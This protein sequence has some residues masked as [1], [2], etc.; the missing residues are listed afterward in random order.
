[1]TETHIVHV[2]PGDELV[3]GDLGGLS[4]PGR[5]VRVDV[6]ESVVQVQ[7]HLTSGTDLVVTEYSLPGRE[8]GLDVLSRVR[9]V[10][11]DL[12]VVLCTNDPDGEVASAATRLGV[13]EYVPRTSDSEDSLRDRVVALLRRETRADGGAAAVQRYAAPISDVINDAVVTIDETSRIVYANEAAADLTGYDREDLL[14]SPF[15]RLVPEEMRDRHVQAVAEYVRT[16][17]R[18]LDW[19]YLELT[20]EDRA[21]AEIPITVSFSEEEMD[22]ERFFTGVIRDVSERVER[23]RELERTNTRLDLALNAID[24]GVFVW[25]AVAD[26]LTWDAQTASLFGLSAEARTVDPSRLHELTIPEHRERLD[27][28]VAA[29][30]EGGDEHDVT[31]CIEHPDGE[32]RWVETHAT[33]V[34]ND[35]G[36]LDRLVGVTRDVTDRRRA[37]LELRESQDALQRLYAITADPD[38][39]FAAKLDAVLELGC[40]RLDLPLGFLTRIQ[41]GDLEIV[42]DHGDDDLAGVTA[43]L[44]ATYCAE[45]VQHDLAATTDAATDPWAQ[46]AYDEFGLACYIGGEIV[47][48]GDTHGTLCFAAEE[49]R[50]SDFTESEETFVELLTQWVGYERERRAREADIRAA[51]DQKHRVL[52]RIDAG[53]FAVDTDWEFTY[54][55][56]RAEEILGFEADDVLGENVWDT[57]PAAMERAFHDEYREAMRTQTPTTFEEYFPPLDTWFAVSAYPSVD[58]LSVYFEDVTERKRRE[59]EL[60]RYETIVE[61]IEDGVYALDSDGR[62]TFANEAL[63]DLTG[64]DREELL[65]R[66]VGLL[67][68]EETVRLGEDVLGHLLS[69]GERETTIEFDLQRAD[70]TSLP[71]EDR[72]TVLP[73]DAGE[74][75]GTA[76]V[77]RD[78]S[79]HRERE[80]T[81]TGLLETTEALMAAP[82]KEAVANVVV[83]AARETLGF[84]LNA[85][86]LYDPESGYLEPTVVTEETKDLLGDRPLYEPGEGFP[87]QVYESGEPVAYDDSQLPD[88][89]FGSVEVAYCLPLGEHGTLTMSSHDIDS[90]DEIDRQVAAILAANA[91]AALDRAERQQDLERYETVM[92]TVQHMVYVLDADGKFTHITRPFS[93]RLGYDREDLV[94]TDAATVIEDPEDLTAIHDGIR[95]LRAPDGPRST[96]LDV[97]ITT[98]HGATFP[99]TV[100]I[101]LLPGDSFEGTVGVVQDV[102]ELRATRDQLADE[103]DRFTYLFDN[104]PDAVV[105]AEMVDGEPIVQS[106]NDAFEDLFGFDVDQIRGESLNDHVLPADEQDAGRRLDSRVAAGDRLQEEVRRQTADGERYFLFRGIPYDVGADGT[107]VFGIYTDITE[108]RNR[109]R[110]LQVL[111]RVL[112]HNIRNELTVILGQADQLRLELEDDRKLAMVDKVLETAREVATMSEKSQEIEQVIGHSVGERTVD[113]A[114]LARRVAAT[115]GREYSDA[116][117]TVDAPESVTVRGDAQL[118]SALGNLVE[119]AIVHNDRDTPHVELSVDIDDGAATVTVADDGPGIPAAERAVITGDDDITQ[120]THASGIGLWLVRWITES[121]GGDLSFTDTA[122]GSEVSLTLDSGA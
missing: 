107:R 35:D 3:G 105:E 92:E 17:E 23:E 38:R 30:Q 39:D 5:S 65:G 6:V 11:P 113:V 110:Q 26:E 61:T 33:A 77:F 68:D 101:S 1:M 19:D 76:G 117:V 94:G 69:A 74:F 98:A 82:T 51:H 28:V 90:F 46:D 20:I 37:T 85:L 2:R 122:V 99:A 95:R 78:I 44:D 63:A 86:R 75:R 93:E 47:V 72:L 112:R 96:D 12:P 62:F 34:R 8:T 60:E 53:F 108:Q 36:S 114:A 10:E 24:G 16:G 7:E 79:G 43:P 59:T 15:T 54:F 27:A 50:R 83:E 111:T 91:E 49:P 42:A 81:L 109:E 88:T 71:C 22:G 121:C 66:H 32:R 4:V 13:T 52:E 18:S 41:D 119:N 64:Y 87:G 56:G 9:Q 67:K 100:D 102:T 118:E 14:G 57:F 40:D 31:Y 116:S 58:G 48:D 21:G 104:L 120:L 25:N 55:N 70:G 29:A 73:M 80:R 84:E 89:D 97:G 106:T 103:R 115:Y 45:T